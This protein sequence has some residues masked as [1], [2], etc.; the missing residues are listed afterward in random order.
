[1]TGGWAEGR[2]QAADPEKTHFLLQGGP[3]ELA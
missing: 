3:M 2:T 1:M